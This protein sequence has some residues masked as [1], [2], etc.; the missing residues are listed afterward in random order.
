MYGEAYNKLKTA[1][2]KLIHSKST[3]EVFDEF[4]DFGLLL[5]KAERTEE[6]NKLLMG[7]KDTYLPMFEQFGE[8]CELA[9]SGDEPLGD[10]FMEY[11]SYGKN[12]QFFTPMDL[13]LMM[14]EMTLGEDQEE[15]SVCDPACGSGRT[16][17]AAGL[18]NRNLWLYGSDIDHRCVKMTALN[19]LIHTMRG[20]VAHMDA[21]SMKHWHSYHIHR[22]NIGGIFLSTWT[23]SGPGET[24]FIERYKNTIEKQETVPHEKKNPDNPT[25]EPIQ[26]KQGQLLM[27]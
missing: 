7:L 11:L 13:C 3:H 25:P 6:Q 23:E 27:F 4:L 19:M 1:F 17:I 8:S 15:K 5:F 16:L 9:A 2:E 24:R 12:G 10:L 14:N 21:L 20:E 22:V 26:T 18:K